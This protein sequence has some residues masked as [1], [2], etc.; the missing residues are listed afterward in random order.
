MRLYQYALRDHYE[1]FVNS[2]RAWVYTSPDAL[3]AEVAERAGSLQSVYGKRVIPDAM[4]EHV[5]AV[6]SKPFASRSEEEQRAI[7]DNWIRV[8]VD[9]LKPD[10]HPTLTRFF[11]FR[12]CIDRMLT[13]DIIGLPQAALKTTSSKPCEKNQKRLNNIQ[14]FF[15]HKATTQLLRRDSLCLQ[16]LGGVEALMA[17]MQKKPC[18]HRCLPR[19]R[20]GS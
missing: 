18:G 9:L 5:A 8:L 17:N 3:G 20:R 15:K 13:M 11:T 16:L 2:I 6:T 10:D 19:K 12:C 1:D 4:L 7:C 14:R